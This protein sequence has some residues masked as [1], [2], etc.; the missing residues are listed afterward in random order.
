MKRFVLIAFAFLSFSASAVIVTCK[1]KS[2]EQ[3][4][5]S[6]TI[7]FFDSELASA[8]VSVDGHQYFLERLPVIDMEYAKMIYLPLD[9]DT[10]ELIISDERFQDWNMGRFST[11]LIRSYFQD[12]REIRCIANK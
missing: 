9:F 5:M 7:N 2:P 6:Y 3:A 8:S 10:F 4:S 11:E 12:T 1:E